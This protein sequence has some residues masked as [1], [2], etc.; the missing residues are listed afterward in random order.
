MNYRPVHKQNRIGFAAVVGMWV[1]LLL[2]TSCAEPMLINLPIASNTPSVLTRAVVQVTQEPT[3][4]HAAT[5]T[6]IKP[7]VTATRTPRVTA[8]TTQTPIPEPA[9]LA[10]QATPLAAAEA[11][12]THCFKDGEVV[13][14]TF[15]SPL[16]DANRNVRVYLPPCYG[17]DGYNYP[18]LY[19]LHGSPQSDAT[20][21]EILG[22]DES[23]ES[24][25]K[26]RKIPPMIIIM[27]DGRPWSQTTSGGERSLEAVI[28]DELI[29]FVEKNWCV[30][31]KRPHR[32]IGGVSRGGYWSTEIAFRYPELFGSVGAHSVAYLDQGDDPE[33]NPL[34]TALNN[35][36]GQ[37]RIYFDFGREDV[38]INT[39]RRLHEQ[40]VEDNIPHEW[41]VHDYGGHTEAYW[42]SQLDNYLRWYAEP[43][44]SKRAAYGVC[45]K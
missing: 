6:T 9:L 30:A 5:P 41:I 10:K 22:L 18:V 21:D 7:T 37:L 1:I 38:L 29:P 12:L 28:I 19:M 25:I 8:T 39:A 3:S 34:Y 33:I 24:L 13:I 16:Q 27:P 44:S 36:L 43:W 4:T 15:Y 23:A 32:A 2:L 42:I 31:R 20:W 14:T 40:M 11:N 35:P 45:R 17:S 26:Q